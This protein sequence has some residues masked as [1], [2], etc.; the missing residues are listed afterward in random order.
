MVC[1]ITA[2]VG[3][4][5]AGGGLEFRLPI[6]EVQFIDKYSLFIPVA[7]IFVKLEQLLMH[8]HRLK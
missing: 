8:A 3:R 2:N 6:T 5:C 1:Q 4:L 7:R